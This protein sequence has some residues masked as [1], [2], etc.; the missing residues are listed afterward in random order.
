M[1]TPAAAPEDVQRL[2][3]ALW[4]AGFNAERV[5]EAM[6]AEGAGFTPNP[7][8]VPAL[9]RLLPPTGALSTLIQLFLANVAVPVDAAASALAP[10]PLA[11]A[12]AIGLLTVAGG[13]ATAKVRLAPA[14]DLVLACD[15]TPD[16]ARVAPDVVV[17]VSASSWSLVHLTVRRPVATAVDIGAGSG[18]QALLA[19][20]HA[21]RVTA[22]DINPRALAF[23][24][25][26]AAL[27]NVAPIEFLEGDLTAPV[28]GR[29]FDLVVSN[30]PFVVS[31]DHD[32]LY[33]DSGHAA[34]G[35]SRQ[36][37]Q[38]AGALLSE[39]GYAHVL[40]S[41]VHGAGADWS[42]PLRDWVGGLG[43][44]AWLL[45][46]GSQDALDYATAWNQ[47]LQGDPERHAAAVGRWI[48]YFARENIEAIGYG[49][50]ILRR[51]S[52]VTWTRAQS[53]GRP[54]DRAANDQVRDL[55]AAMDYLASQTGPDRLLDERFAFDQPHRLHQ[56]LRLREGAFHV[57]EAMLHLES[58]LALRAA[59]DAYSAHLL[60]CMDGRKTLEEAVA[61]S[62]RVLAPDAD[63][64]ELRRRT[65][66]LV[67][68]MVE[69]GILRP[70]TMPGRG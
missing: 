69:L 5:A 29:H 40:V 1:S 50:V 64:A 20:R 61:D 14:E 9:L 65:V 33:R 15:L 52:G 2:R 34:D 21:T 4:A 22:T 63:R 44:D 53:L 12:E 13:E 59:V 28:A 3:E 49:A 26:S 42:Q 35:V 57:D 31:P 54:P 51:R 36:V 48:D 8:H 67:E 10:L 43:C 38:D 17:G 70:S 11:R 16:I 32:Y 37:V 27:N 30:P 7:A 55:F 60:T 18:I 23:A 24:R 68:R 25:F 47:P 6:R 66:D 45:H 62:A 46:F 56:V 19:A 58:G 41:W 39:G